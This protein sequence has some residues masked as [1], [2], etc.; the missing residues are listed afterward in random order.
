[1]HACKH[2]HLHTHTQHI[3]TCTHDTIQVRHGDHA[4][5]R[6]MGAEYARQREHMERSVASLRKKLA[7]DTEIH[8]KDN[9]RVMQVI[10]C[11]IYSTTRVMPC[12]INRS[13]SIPVF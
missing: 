8:R 12:S 7:K 6:D 2:I 3:H 11:S 4:A 10:S 1:M 13:C 5:E 9:I